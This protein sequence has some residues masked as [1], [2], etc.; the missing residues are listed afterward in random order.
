M[1]WSRIPTVA[2]LKEE[3]ALRLVKSQ[4]QRTWPRTEIV[5]LLAVCA[6]LGWPQGIQ[7]Q[8]PPPLTISPGS[9][10]L[11]DGHYGGGYN[12]ANFTASGGIPFAPP[13]D[14]Y[15]WSVSGGLPPGTQFSFF[16]EFASVSASPVFTALGTFNFTLEVTD[17]VGTKV[18]QNYSITV[19]YLFTITSLSPPFKLRDSTDFFLFVNG[20]GLFDLSQS[21]TTVMWNGSPLPT[22]FVNPTRLQAS[23]PSAFLTQAAAVDINV[24]FESDGPEGLSNVFTF[25]VTNPLPAITSLSPDSRAAGTGGFTL[26]VNGTN[27]VSDSTL[28]WNGL[29]RPT[30]FV[31]SS[32][33]TAVISDSDIQASGTAQVSVANKAPGGGNS[34]TLTFQ[35]GPSPLTFSYTLTG[36]SAVPISPGG[37]VPF[38]GTEIGSSLSA[39]F[40]ATNAGSVAVVISSITVGNGVFSLAS[41]PALPVNL[42]PS[43]SLAFTITFSPTAQ[44]TA[45]GTLDVNGLTFSLSGTTSRPQAPALNITDLTDTVPPAE[46][47]A[48][49]VS[50]T[51]AYQFDISGTATLTFA[52]D[53]VNPSDDPNITFVANGQR[54][55]NFT[56]PANSTQAVFAGQTEFQTGTVA[57][58]IA[59]NVTLQSGGSDVTPP[60]SSRTITISRGAPVISSVTVTSGF[61]VQ[62]I[63]FSTPREMVAAAFNFTARSGTLQNSSISVDVGSPFTTYYQ[64]TASTEFGSQFRLTVPFSVQGGASI[65]S[66]SVTLRNSVGTSTA[67]S[68]NF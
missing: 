12:S 21:V 22:V 66:V 68:A 20:S 63:G 39:Q 4:H 36:Q 56:I 32:Q 54:T 19:V 48:F 6:L 23:V 35:I 33:V 51:G 3:A 65:G 49:G 11:P 53:A 16:Q 14:P 28:Y 30:T 37:T 45:S 50:L 46:Q 9:S 29:P 52:P 5:A 58:A 31:S 17:S 42:A 41:L 57:G 59:L 10:Q 61:S 40:Q 62:V 64:G 44:G 13:S 7:A 43:S 34:N 67:V 2:N 47:P 55:L 1:K 60:G 24:L 26:T 25:N 38:P 18:S 27:F 15:I 8:G